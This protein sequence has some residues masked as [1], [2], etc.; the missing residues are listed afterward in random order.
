M[1]EKK[2]TKVNLIFFILVFF[3]AKSSQAQWQADIRL[4][5]DHAVSNTSDNN[6]RCVESSGNVV[7]VVWKDNRDGNYEIY[8]KQSIDGGIS[9]GTDTRL[10]HNTANSLLPTLYVAGS[11]VNIVWQDNRD[12]NYEIY[13]KRSTDGGIHWGTDTRLTSNSAISRNPSMT[14]FLSTVN[15]VWRD[16]RDGNYEIYYKHSTDGGM[17]WGADTRLTNNPADSY[18]PSISQNASFVNVVWQDNRDGNYEIYYKRSTDGGIVWETDARLTNNF[19]VSYNPIVSVSDSTVHVIWRDAREGNYDLFYKRS[20]DGGINWGI[21]TR[22]THNTADSLVFSAAISGLAIHLVWEDNRDGNYEI[23][24]KRSTNAG[25]TW[26]GDTRLTNNHAFS[27]YA[28]VSV[29][30]SAVHVVW[31]D[32]RDGNDEIYYKRNPTGNPIG[33]PAIVNSKGTG[34][35]KEFSLTQNYPNPFNPK[36]IINYSIPNAQF[37]KLKVY[38]ALGNEVAVLV[39]ENQEAGTYFVEFDGGNL[40]SGI[41]FYK[42]VAGNFKK[43]LKMTLVK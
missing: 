19:A 6:A 20:S 27:F 16:N 18:N 41:Y 8:Y 9:W 36:T 4:T 38:D 13:Y 26:E 30:G 28:F 42:I 10:T 14:G 32:N 21:D 15:I 34:I 25:V 22:L 43:V 31:Y 37:I 3:T 39:N 11:V 29:S 2:L 33:S 24:Y 12:G 5:N 23:Y 17:H 1:L 35:P 7:H 40:S